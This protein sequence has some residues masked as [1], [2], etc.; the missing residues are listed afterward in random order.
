MRVLAFLLAA[1]VSCAAPAE[2]APPEETS[3]ACLEA[4]NH[5]DL[6]WIEQNVFAPS[7]AAFASCHQGN[8][9]SAGGLDLEPGMAAHSLVDVASELAPGMALVAPGS[10][11]ESYLLVIL[12]HYGADD[13]RID[14]SV[15]TMPA[16]NDL[17][18]T[19]KRNAIERW[20][21][22]LGGD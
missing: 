21:A 22:E 5:S 11:E 18:C 15:G 16:S 13:P 17:L 14:P 20:I 1:H 12:G 6:D 3:P 19:E 2:E 10:P 8:A 4:S 7:C 9:P